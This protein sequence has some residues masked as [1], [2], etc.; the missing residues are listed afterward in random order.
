MPELLL[1]I[2]TEEIPSGFMP[3]ALEA[4][5]ELIQKEFQTH[6]LGFEEIKS[7]GTP[8]RLVLT[9]GGVAPAQEKRFLEVLGP[10]KRIAFDEK[11][12]PTKAALGFAKGQGIPVEELQIV[13]T[14]KGE[15]LCARKEEKGEETARL[16]PAILTR[17]ISSI[18]FPKSMR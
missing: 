10:A 18:P 4:M 3:R 14:E 11:G 15:Y 2:G 17:L 5:K 6:R 8:R 7:L 16:L 13:K 9:A 12:E 1:E